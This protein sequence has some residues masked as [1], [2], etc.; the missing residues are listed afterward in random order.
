MAQ[1]YNCTFWRATLERR[2]DFLAQTVS[3]YR[4]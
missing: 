1:A 2:Y 3:T 4:L